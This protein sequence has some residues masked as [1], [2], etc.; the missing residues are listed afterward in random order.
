M[1]LLALAACSPERAVESWRVLGDIAAAGGPSHLKT[2]TPPPRRAAVAYRID[3]RAYIGD[4]YRPGD[5]PRAA[6]VLVPGAVPEGK[7]DPRLVVFAD[8][9]ARARFT[10]LVPEIENLRALCVRPS[11]VQHIADA[12]RY[13]AAARASGDTPGPIGIAAISY[14][15]GPA[16][17]AALRPEVREDVSFLV[18]VGGYYD[19]EAVIAF[20]TTGGFREGANEPWQ[21]GTPNAYGKWLFVRANADRLLDPRDRMLLISMAERKLRDLNAGIADLTGMLGP[22]GSSVQ[23]LLTNVDPEAV[24][25]LIAALPLAIRTDLEALDVRRHDLSTLAARLI[26]IHGRDDTIIPYSESL[27]LAAAAPPRQTALYVVD[28]LAHVKLGPGGIVDG[29]RLWRAVYRLLEERDVNW[30]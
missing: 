13:L 19:M 30:R 8:T 10:V 24:P 23:A 21:Y 28:N 18:A 12:V 14:A 22:E 4:L 7:D 15:A 1:A 3:S 17:L 26:L 20:F 9:L 2:I 29:L 11:D 6:L 27:A 5:T 16:V 25:A